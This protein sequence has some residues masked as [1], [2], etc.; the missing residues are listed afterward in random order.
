MHE[1]QLKYLLAIA[2][3]GQIQSAAQEL[4]ITPASLRC[5]LHR[6]EKELGVCLF[7]RQG[8][9]LLPTVQ[10]EIVLRYGRRLLSKEAE[11]KQ[12]LAQEHLRQTHRV[13]LSIC[14]S[15]YIEGWLQSF[16]LTHPQIIL[17]QRLLEQD[18]LYTALLHEEMDL[19]FDRWEKNVPGLSAQ[20][21][22]EDTYL[23]VVPPDHPLAGQT[24]VSMAQLSEL[25][26]LCLPPSSATTRITDK[27]FR[28]AGLAPNIVYEGGRAMLNQLFAAKKGIYFTSRQM[29]YLQDR[30][31]HSLFQ[32]AS[33]QVLLPVCDPGSTFSLALFWKK[34]RQ[35]PALAQQLRQHILCQYPIWSQ[36]KEQSNL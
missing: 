25:P 7:Q 28:Q 22:L 1:K 34:D 23:A 24:S 14:N 32:R 20:V 18:A 11:L 10:G 5:A 33:Q 3:K 35:L 13:C 27:L 4:Y 15:A 17:Q 30:Y 16:L 26:V 6:I 12:A 2:Q 21:L 36:T 8:E 29:A 31:H 9:K 19:G